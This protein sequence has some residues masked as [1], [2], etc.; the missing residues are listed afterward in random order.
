[1]SWKSF[2]CEV[3]NFGK[4]A[5]VCFIDCLKRGFAPKNDGTIKNNFHVFLAMSLLFT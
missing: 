2:C 4:Q 1:M 5:D 3:I